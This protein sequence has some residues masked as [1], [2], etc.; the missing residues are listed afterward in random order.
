MRRSS[1]T[2]AYGKRG[3]LGG[4]DAGIRRVASTFGKV[5]HLTGSSKSAERFAVD[6]DAER[7]AAHALTIDPRVTRFTPQ[8]LTV[9][10]VDGRLLRTPDDVS[11]ARQKHRQRIG[12]KF[13]TPDFGIER[14][15]NPHEVAEVKLEGF[16]GDAEYNVTLQQGHEV[17]DAAGYRFTRLVIPADARHPLRANLPLLKKAT[18]RKD[19][20]PDSELLARVEDAC[21]AGPIPLTDVCRKLDLSPSLIPVLLVCGAVRADVVRQRIY[22]PMLLE[23]AYGELAHLHLIEELIR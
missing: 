7:L 13:Y 10:L 6:S 20:W 5:L 12:R 23:A 21:G 16:E 11:A 17:L 1:S 22:G 4:A 18:S 19:L 9:D 8:P 14:V 3:R 15:D 2:I